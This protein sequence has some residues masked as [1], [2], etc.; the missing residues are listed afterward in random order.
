M[1][2]KK[3]LKGPWGVEPEQHVS[4]VL[5]GSIYPGAACICV[6]VCEI[7]NGTGRACVRV[8]VCECVCVASRRCPKA[9]GFVR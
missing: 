2:P 6:C 7:E 4:L 9:L 1:T 8:C 3:S 5:L